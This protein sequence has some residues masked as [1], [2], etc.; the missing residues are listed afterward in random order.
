MDAGD[1]LQDDVDSGPQATGDLHTIKFRAWDWD[2]NRPLEGLHVAFDAPDGLRYETVS[3]AHGDVVFEDVDWPEGATAAVVA[4]RQG[5]YIYGHVGLTLK[6]FSDGNVVTVGSQRRDLSDLTVE[7]GGTAVNMADNNAWLDVT[8]SAPA[9]RSHRDVGRVYAVHVPPHVPFILSGQAWRQ[10]LIGR[11][12][13]NDILN[14]WRYDAEPVDGAMTLDL[15]DAMSPYTESVRGTVAY[16]GNNHPLQDKGILFMSA[17]SAEPGAGSLV[18]GLCT[19]TVREPDLR[20]YTFEF[21]QWAQNENAIVNTI[22]ITDGDQNSWQAIEGRLAS[23]DYTLYFPIPLQVTSLDGG[24]QDL[25]APIEFKN[26]EPALHVVL[27]V[28]EWG[29]IDA[30]AGASALT[31]PLPP[32]AADNDFEVYPSV[33]SPPAESQLMLCGSSRP[34]GICEV[35]AL[36]PAFKLSY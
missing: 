26:R 6:D 24:E 12:F 15:T 9:S 29:R 22:Y 34:D 30:P 20:R 33:F 19:R 8:T 18:M 7:V 31:V 28:W 5:F 2:L 11:E 13:N 23:G 21:E 27:F 25:Y 10:S 16:P 35:G 1:G 17:T 4:Y 14:W 3:D 36:S 32:S